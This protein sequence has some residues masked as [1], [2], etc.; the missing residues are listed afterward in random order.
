[1]STQRPTPLRTP[2]RI[3]AGRVNEIVEARV[4][5][6][7]GDGLIT[8]R[9]I[10]DRVQVGLN[11]HKLW[12][13]LPK[14]P[15]AMR[16]VIKAASAS[17][18]LP[19]TITYTIGFHATTGDPSLSYTGKTP[20]YRPA[21]TI[22]VTA[23][24]VGSD[25]LVISTRDEDDKPDLDLILC[26]EL[27]ITEECD[28]ERAASVLP[29]HVEELMFDSYG[30][31]LLT[32][33]PDPIFGSGVFELEEADALRAIL[34]DAY[35]NPILDAFGRYTVGSVE[36]NQQYVDAITRIATDAYGRTM[37][38]NDGRPITLAS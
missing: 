19:N 6:I 21:D 11:L 5:D 33:E 25:C 7:T 31:L 36:A 2:G 30:R 13:S 20:W 26:S 16:G 17:S 3:T 4:L 23:A 34:I 14:P 12:A 22:E 24:Q 38:D 9:R 32:A 27:L 28:P 18:G 37:L 10:G 1:M 35:G 15:R 29:T 8:V